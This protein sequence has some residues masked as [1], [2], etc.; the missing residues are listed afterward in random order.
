MELKRY[1]QL[2]GH[3]YEEAKF[4]IGI[5]TILISRDSDEP[6]YNGCVYIDSDLFTPYIQFSTLFDNDEETP[7]AALEAALKWIKAQADMTAW[8]AEKE[9]EDLKDQ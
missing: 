2:S 9:L 5:F 7:E 8:R 1:D 3:F 4:E 6:S